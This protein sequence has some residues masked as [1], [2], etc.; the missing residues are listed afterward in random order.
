MVAEEETEPEQGEQND[1][2]V[3]QDPNFETL[4][5]KKPQ[6]RRMARGLRTQELP[7]REISLEE[8]EGLVC[9]DDE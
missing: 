8:M 1:I 7:S 2:E 9:I 3:N 5:E 6:P 4:K